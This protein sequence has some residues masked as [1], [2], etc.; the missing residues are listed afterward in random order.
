MRE[1]L[2]QCTVGRWVVGGVPVVEQVM[3]VISGI[4]QAAIIHLVIEWPSVVKYTSLLPSRVAGHLK[5]ASTTTVSVSKC[6]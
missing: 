1:I 6:D 5:R 3:V 4:N 2:R